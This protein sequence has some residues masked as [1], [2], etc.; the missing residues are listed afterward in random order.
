MEDESS[1]ICQNKQELF[2][3][4]AVTAGLIKA[5]FAKKALFRF[6]VKGFSMFPF[7]QDGDVITLSPVSYSPI[8]LGKSV[9]CVCP[10]TKRL[11]VHRIVGKKK[12]RYLVKGDNIPKADGLID[13]EHILGYV[14]AIE[15]KNKNIFFS[16]GRERLLIAFL[17]RT[18]L[19]LLIFS[20]CRLL[21]GSLRRFIKRRILS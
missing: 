15:R 1:C 12:G 20:L 8:G 21:P 19:M 14:T 4:N 6:K 16:L 9:A 13:K 3:S 2:L 18:G 5:V 10:V 17:N 11:I 7:I